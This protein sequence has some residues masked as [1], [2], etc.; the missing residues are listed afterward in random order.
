MVERDGWLMPTGLHLSL[1][2][3]GMHLQSQGRR[4]RWDWGWGG[5]SRNTLRLAMILNSS[6][7]HWCL[8]VTP[9]QGHRPAYMVFGFS[10]PG[11]HSSRWSIAAC[12]VPEVG[13]EGDSG[14]GSQWPGLRYSVGLAVRV[15]RLLGTTM[16][17]WYSVS[18]LAKDLNFLASL[19]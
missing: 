15:M 18:V 10:S 12:C 8:M 7:S 3:A 6:L 9:G 1:R 19:L 16:M 5:I 14:R 13:G 11:Y 2:A 17:Y 4:G